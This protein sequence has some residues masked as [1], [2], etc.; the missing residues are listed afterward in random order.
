MLRKGRWAWHLVKLLVS[1]EKMESEI[2]EEGAQMYVYANGDNT[3][4][5]L[6]EVS[7]LKGAMKRPPTVPI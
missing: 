3:L 6:D 4:A 1:R 7:F 5:A 2:Y